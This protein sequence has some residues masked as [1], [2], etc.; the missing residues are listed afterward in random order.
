M[1][2]RVVKLT[3]IDSEELLL[4]ATHSLSAVPRPFL[5]WAGSKQ[6]LL[7]SIAPILPARYGTYYEPFLGSASLFFLLQPKRAVLG[8][9]CRDLMETYRAVRDGAAHVLRFLSP[10]NPLSK[11]QYYDV[12]QN[13]SSGRF[14]RAAEFIFLNRAGWNGLYRVNSRGEFN[15]PY[16]APSSKLLIDDTNLRACSRLLRARTIRLARQDFAETLD[17]AERGDLVFLDP[18]YVTGH[19]NNGFVDY[20]ESLFSWDD[21]LR[22][23]QVARRLSAR[24]VRV[25]VTN[26]HHEPVLALYPQFNIRPIDRLSTLAGDTSRRRGVREALIWR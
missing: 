8:D 2:S 11:A 4:R 18:P 14:K 5:R 22:L 17:G 6:R 21:Q 7:R 24:G 23:A 16:G 19:N 1:T 26:A 10:L 13:R 25:V 20:N 9:S 3:D 15:V 12:R